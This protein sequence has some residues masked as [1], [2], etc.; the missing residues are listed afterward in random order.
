VASPEAGTP[1]EGLAGYRAG[2]VLAVGQWVAIG[3]VAAG[4]LVG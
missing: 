4:F 2:A 3:V 1:D